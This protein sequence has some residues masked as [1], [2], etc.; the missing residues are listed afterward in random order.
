MNSGS[1]YWPDVSELDGAKDATQVGMWCAVAVAGFTV[2]SVFLP[3]VFFIGVPK[4]APATLA[5]GV[6]FGAIA[7]GIS[8]YSRFAAVA[9]FVLFLLEKIYTYV[10]TGT[11]LGVGVVGVILLIGFLNGVRG[12][13][14]FHKL[15]A[16]A[17][18]QPV[19]PPAVSN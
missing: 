16:T 4:S 11:I 19:S 17:D 7:Y 9:G 10:V 3:F 2:I 5:D 1:W 14:A 18:P 12:A 15:P 13:F 8:R 6:V